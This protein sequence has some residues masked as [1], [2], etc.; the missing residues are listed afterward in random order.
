LTLSNASVEIVGNRVYKHFLDKEVAKIELLWYKDVPWATPE[1]LDYDDMTIVTEFLP[2]ASE[3]ENW[4][5]VKETLNLIL[6][7]HENSIHHRDVHAANLVRG[8][9]GLPRF[10][11]WETAIY[12][13]SEHSYD[14]VGGSFGGSDARRAFGGWP[15][16]VGSP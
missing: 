4:R 16:V 9:D 10:I 2:V 11:D 13:E 5:P 15:S 7:L 6:R 14:L 3:N 8:S 12:F 1:L